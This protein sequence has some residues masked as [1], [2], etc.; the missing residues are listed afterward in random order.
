M[1]SASLVHR[2]PG[3]TL[4]DAISLFFP[5]Y[6]EEGN[7][8]GAV[9][10]ALDALGAATSTFEVI[11]VDDGSGDQTGPIADRLAA[12]DPRVRVV[13]HPTNRGYGAAM[14]SGLDAARYPLVVLADG[15]NQFD[16]RELPTLLCALHG[17]E[18]VS[19]YRIARR[20]PAFRRLYAFLYNHTARLLFD[21]RIRDVNCGFKVYR[22]AA[23]D[24]VLQELRSTGALIN[25][26]LLARARERGLRVAEVGVHHYPRV[27]GNQTGGNPA[28]ILRAFTELVRLWR[29]LR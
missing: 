13:H 9:G 15:D 2:H 14:R 22:R 6:N 5:M 4:T 26:E 20:D 12:A 27:A 1:S 17:H 21:V 10:A 28:V 29:E 24:G 8:E 19:G 25:V 18:I 7:I 23:L 16:L 3:D 11:V